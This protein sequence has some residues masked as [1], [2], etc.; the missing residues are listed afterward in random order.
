MNTSIRKKFD[1]LFFHLKPSEDC[2]KFLEANGI[3]SKRMK[4]D[5]ERD[6]QWL[7]KIEIVIQTVAQSKNPLDYKIASHARGF[8]RVLLRNKKI[9]EKLLTL[10]EKNEKESRK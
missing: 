7:E 10:I 9:S 6:C 8:K 5:I 2:K 4:E 1:S 3:N